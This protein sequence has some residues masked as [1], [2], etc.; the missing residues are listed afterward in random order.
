MK[1]ITEEISNVKIIKEGKKGQPQKL[2]I[3]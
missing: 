1:L 2:Y 3:E